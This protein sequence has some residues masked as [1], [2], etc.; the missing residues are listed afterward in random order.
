MSVEIV[1]SHLDNSEWRLAEVAALALLEHTHDS[2]ERGV[3]LALLSRANFRLGRPSRALQFGEEAASLTEHWE[4]FP[5]GWGGHACS[6][7]SAGR[8]DLA[9][10]GC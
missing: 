2:D 5:V 6:R 9:D 1:R 8:E 3:L 7:R 4:A 10:S